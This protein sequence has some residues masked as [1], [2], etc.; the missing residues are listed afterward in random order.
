MLHCCY[1]EQ[2]RSYL[3]PNLE[4]AQFHK[5]MQVMEEEPFSS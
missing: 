1:F 3:V 5:N 4:L 2:N